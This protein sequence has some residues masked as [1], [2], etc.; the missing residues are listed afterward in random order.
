M[1]QFKIPHTC[2][3]NT[4]APVKFLINPDLGERMEACGDYEVHH[5]SGLSTARS[6]E[7]TYGQQVIGGDAVVVT[8]L[9]GENREWN[10]FRVSQLI[11]RPWAEKSEVA[12]WLSEILPDLLYKVMMQELDE[13]HDML[14]EVQMLMNMTTGRKNHP[15]EDYDPFDE[16]WDFPHGPEKTHPCTNWGAC[17]SEGQCL[18][19]DTCRF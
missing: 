11:I 6:G 13:E 9:G 17:I 3:R 2:L 15:L 14:D 18:H 19:P 7:V 1:E 12:E 16:Y 5:Y 8:T 4:T 10:I